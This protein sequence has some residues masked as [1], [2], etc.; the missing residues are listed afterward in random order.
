[1]PACN[2]AARLGRGQRSAR[3]ARRAPRLQPPARGARARGRV[4]AGRTERDRDGLAQG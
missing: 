2:R 4:E 3:K 1:M